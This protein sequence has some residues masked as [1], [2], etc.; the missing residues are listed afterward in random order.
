M[1]NWEITRTQYRVS[2]FLSWQRAKSLVLSPS[3]QRRPVWK[4]GAKSYLIDTVARGLPMPI[5]FLREQKTSLES[6]EPKREVVDGQQRLRTLMSFIEPKTLTDYKKERDDFMV[7]KNHNS[8]LEGKRFAE[9]SPEL[10]RRILDYQFSV[11]VL[12]AHVGDRDVIQLFA[13]MNATGVQLNEQELRNAEYYGA[14]KTCVYELGSEQLQR[15]REWHVF[16]EYDIARMQEVETVSEFAMLDVRGVTGKSQKAINS[17]YKEND[18]KYSE[19][20]SFEKKFRVTMDAINDKLGTLLPFSPFRKKAMFYNLFAAIYGRHYGLPD[21]SV[22]KKASPMSSA[23]IEWLR[24]AS[25]KIEDETAPDNV[26]EAIARRTTHP[27]SR[28]AV[29]NY[30]A[31]PA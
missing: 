28:L 1:E 15:W 26:L 2:D 6:L 14:F 24:K 16:S 19:R 5:I 21:G 22:E 12:P 17:F 29:I 8:E 7:L 23:L 18:E 25:E 30:L 3:F 31:K 27:S 13:R 9:L 4:S 10:K 20:K 11:H